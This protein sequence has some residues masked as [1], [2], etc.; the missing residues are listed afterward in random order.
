[1]DLKERGWMWTG[2]MW[3]TIRA[4]ACPSV[5]QVVNLQSSKIVV[6]LTRQGT[7]SS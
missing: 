2:F 6:N 3:R 5:N 4:K 1:M 7:T